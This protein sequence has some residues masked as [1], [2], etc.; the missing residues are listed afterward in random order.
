MEAPAEDTE[1]TGFPAA[2]DGEEYW[3]P[4]WLEGVRGDDLAPESEADVISH[5]GGMMVCLGGRGSRRVSLRESGSGT[6]WL[7]DSVVQKIEK[8]NMMQI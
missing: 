1:R 4:G 2:A 7:S 6:K 3:L 8:S 5:L